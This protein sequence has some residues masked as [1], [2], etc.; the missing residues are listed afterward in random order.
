MLGSVTYHRKASKNSQTLVECLHVFTPSV[1]C[2]F[3]PHQCVG[4]IIILILNI[5]VNLIVK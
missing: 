5:T 1:C 4:F 3:L 2:L